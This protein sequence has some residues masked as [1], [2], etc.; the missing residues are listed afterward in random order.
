MF[1]FHVFLMSV[2]S[3]WTNLLRSLLATLGVIIGVVAVVTAMS[4]LQGFRSQFIGTFE[5]MGSNLLT[6]LPDRQRTGGGRVAGNLDSLKFED[7]TALE[8]IERIAGAAPELLTLSSIKYHSKQS[9]A[10]VLGTSERYAEMYNYEM[11]LGRFIDHEDVVTKKRVV[12][13]GHKASRD[14]FGTLDPTRRKVRIDGKSFRVVGVIAKKGAQGFRNVDEQ[15]VV[16][17]TTAMHRLTGSNSVQSIVV[18]ARDPTQMDECQTD[19]KKLL[20]ERHRISPGE[21][22]DF[23]FVRQ[24]DLISTFANMTQLVAIVL[25]SIAG[26]SLV[27]GGIGIMN[28]MLVAVTERTREIGV[29]MAVGAQRGDILRQFLAESGIISSLGGGFGI[30]VSFL[31]LDLLEQ[32]TQILETKTPVSIIV[33]ALTMAI[34]TGVVSGIYPAWKAS[35]LDPVEALRYE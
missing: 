23:Q 29:R 13:L 6:I 28:I 3:L 31:F 24:E 16:P 26:I 17:I 15:V 12:V 2:R 35:R 19:A 22:D 10:W 5:S 25:Y 7:A 18:Q 33:W 4:I 32:V 21:K 1:V 9:N 14:L 27:V 20:R 11:T 30:V 8:K 34:M